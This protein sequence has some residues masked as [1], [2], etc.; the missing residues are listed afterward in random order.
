[1]EE[2]LPV[3]KPTSNLGRLST[4]LRER[5]PEYVIE[6]LVIVLSISASFALD[7]WKDKQRKQELE[8]LYLKELARDIESDISQLT[9]IIAET[10]QVISKASGLI[11]LSRQG[12][13]PD[14]SQVISDIRFTFKRPRFVAQ[15]ATF[16]DLKSTGNMQSLSNFSLKNNLFNYYKQY[17]SIVLIETAELEVTNAL[18]GPYMVR[19]LPLMGESR[20]DQKLI[21]S[22]LFNEIEFQNSMLLRQS[23]RQE[24]LQEYSQVLTQGKR[25]LAAIKSQPI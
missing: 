17:E 16:S 13:Q 1:M 21:L 19:R 9:E 11:N 6:I 2:D 10:K 25:I 4:L 15:D 8:Q 3:Q 12:S 5:W 23:T 14:Y 20:K 18:I 24:L 22:G 7:E